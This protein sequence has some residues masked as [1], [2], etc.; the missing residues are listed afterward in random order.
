MKYETSEAECLGIESEV[1]GL[2]HREIAEMLEISDK[3]VRRH[4]EGAKLW[5]HR[6]INS[7]GQGSRD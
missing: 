7:D 5:L 2:K 4:W 3:T 1:S 6:A